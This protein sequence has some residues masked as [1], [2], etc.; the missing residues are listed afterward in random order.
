V[1]LL[2]FSKRFGIARRPLPE[3]AVNEPDVVAVAG[4]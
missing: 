3:D 1:I 2:P 4:R